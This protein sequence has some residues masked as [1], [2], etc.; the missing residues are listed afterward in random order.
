MKENKIVL[1]NIFT[2]EEWV[3]YGSNPRAKE[4]IGLPRTSWSQI[5]TFKGK[6]GF[7][8]GLLG[9]F[10]WVRNKLLREQYPDQG[11]GVFGTEV[12]EYCQ[13]RKHKDKFTAKEKKVLNK[14]KPL[15]IFEQPTV[16]NINGVVVVG[17]IDDLSSDWKIMRDFKTKSESSKKDLFEGEK[18]QMELYSLF[19]QQEKNF[20]P[21]C[22]Y[23][24]IERLGGAACFKGGGR[25]SLTVG[26]QVWYE[27]YEITEDRLQETVDLITKVT[28]DMSDFYKVFLKMQNK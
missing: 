11:W 26:E 10:E 24:I 27:P 1:P 25:E 12:Q 6:K 5:E 20:L 2:E 16:I 17:F 4:W 7:N 19:I 3:Q 13:E 21:E 15:Q 8:T 22:S 23:V 9:K 28:K 18:Y 14:V